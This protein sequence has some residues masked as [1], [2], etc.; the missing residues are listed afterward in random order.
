MIPKED[1][2]SGILESRPDLYGPF[3]T[4]TT[5]I[6]A[7][8]VFSSL[9]SSIASYLS[10]KVPSYSLN[11]PSSLKSNSDLNLNTTLLSH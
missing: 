6:F 4:L 3:W 11:F 8:F 7:L 1:Y 9:A 10:E 2:V 5:V